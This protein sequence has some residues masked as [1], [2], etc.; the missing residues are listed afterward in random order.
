MN[1]RER[2][3][4]KFVLLTGMALISVV[5]LFRFDHVASGIL[6]QF[7][8]P[9]GHI[10]LAGIFVNCS[11]SLYGIIMQHTVHG[12]LWEKAGQGGLAGQFLIYGIW[13]F[14]LFSEKATGFAGL[15]VTLAIA[16]ILRVVQIDRRRRKAAKHGPS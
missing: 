8:R 10:L 2:D 5:M 6:L 1:D 14:G 15:L 7:P 4:Y 16:A 12:V 3:P 13:G 11:M 9:W